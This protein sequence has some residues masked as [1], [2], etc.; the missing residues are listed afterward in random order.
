MDQSTQ[1]IILTSVAGALF[2]LGVP[3]F[4]C[5]ATWTLLASFIIDFTIQNIGVTSYQGISSYA[6]LAMPLF[7]VAGELISAGGGA[8]KLSALPATVLRP[9]RGGMSL[10]AIATCSIF[11]AISGSNS[12]IVATVGRTLIPEMKRQG[13]DPEFAAA[14][15]AAGGIVGIL[16][17]PSLLMVIYGFMTNLSII[18]LFTAGWGPGI[19][20]SLGLAGGAIYCSRKHKWGGTEPFAVRDSA[21]ALWDAKLGITTMVLVLVLIYGGYSSPTEAA[22]V[23]ACYCILIGVFVTEQIKLKDIPGIFLASGRINGMLAPTIAISIVMQQILSIVGVPRLVYNFIYA[24][25]EPWAMMLMMM[26]ALVLFGSIMES[27]SVCIILAP[28]MAPIAAAAG[29]NPY[30][31]ALVFIVGLS[32]GFITPPFAL[33][34]FVASGVTGIPYGKIIRWISPFIIGV[35]IAWLLIAFYPP[36]TLALFKIVGGGGGF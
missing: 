18:D 24:F 19:C 2:V 31:F 12:A 1:L 30:H 7:I 36:I 14:S 17:P 28:I 32:L 22:S 8:A 6:L 33:D 23:V 9:I 26:A 13:Y 10:A 34:L 29:Y 25:Q 11:S 15:T 3:I 21:R 5:M 35:C 4:L 16:I 20:V 27:I